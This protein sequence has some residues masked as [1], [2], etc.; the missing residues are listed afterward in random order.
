MS[1]PRRFDPSYR[2]EVTL[3]DGTRAELRLV[4]PDDK[5]LF[6]E[7]FARLSSQSRYLRF[8]TGKPSLSESEL[9]YLTELDGENHLAIGAVSRDEEGREIPLGVVRFVRLPSE[10]EVA[11]LAVTVID[12][13]QRKG[14]G[15]VLCERIAR[16]ARERGIVRVRAEILPSNAAMLG[17]MRDL[18]HGVQHEED[19]CVVVDFEL[20]ELAHDEPPNN[21]IGQLLALA[22]KG[23]ILVRRVLGV[24]EP[25]ESGSG[26]KKDLI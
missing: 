4:T 20:P 14:L 10:P 13:M 18:A 5:H 3:R 2:E 15:R 12:D 1:E 17:L 23:L 16:A 26:E 19:G 22:G 11:E 24:N 9:R 7:G 21:L 6:T 8:F 25:R